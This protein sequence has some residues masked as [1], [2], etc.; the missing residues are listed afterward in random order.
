[1]SNSKYLR[2]A[3]ARLAARQATFDAMKPDERKGY[4]RPGSMQKNRAR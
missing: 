1:M 3:R 2:R 4:R